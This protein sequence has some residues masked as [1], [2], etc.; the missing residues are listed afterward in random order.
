MAY[1]KTLLQCRVNKCQW[2]DYAPPQGTFRKPEIGHLW[3][4]KC[5]VCPSIRYRAVHR[6]TGQFVQGTNWKHL[7]PD[8]WRPL[9]TMDNND[10]RRLYFRALGQPVRKKR[11]LSAVKTA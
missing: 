7:R 3:V 2:E 6:I 8:E 10:Y 11:H 9:K 1:P 5:N 4:Q